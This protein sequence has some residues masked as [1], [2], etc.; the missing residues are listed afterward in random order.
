MQTRK[1]IASPAA[2]RPT[3]A[4]P[5]AERVEQ[6]IR[7]RQMAAARK[8]YLEAFAEMK[9]DPLAARAK[10]ES[11]KTLAGP[12]EPLWSAALKWIA[13]IDEASAKRER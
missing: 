1:P 10:F 12:N 13:Q 6:E 4:A 8:L 7:S 11:V 5:E 2:P 9:K 3:P